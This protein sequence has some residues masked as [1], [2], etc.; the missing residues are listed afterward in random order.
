M[1]QTGREKVS[2]GVLV[3]ILP[4]LNVVNRVYDRGLLPLQAF[5]LSD[6]K[7]EEASPAYMKKWVKILVVGETISI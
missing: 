2:W 4:S 5:W 3:K 7:A 6:K 1:D